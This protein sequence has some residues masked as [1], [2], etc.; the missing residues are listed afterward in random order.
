[1]LK[2]EGQQQNTHAG[3]SLGVH[4]IVGGDSSQARNSHIPLDFPLA[5]LTPGP[6]VCFSL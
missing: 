2:V 1:M 3:P 5:P 4:I 6:S